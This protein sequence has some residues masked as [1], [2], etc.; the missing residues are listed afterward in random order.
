MN[1][2]EELKKLPDKPGAYIMK[3]VQGQIIYI[4]KAINLKNR[5]RSYFR[6]S[7]P[8]P[9]VASM[10][11][12]IDSFEYIVTDSELEA[13]ILECNLI[14]EHRPRYNILLKDDKSYPY[15]V[16]TVTESYPRVLMAHRQ[17][18][19]KNK[20]FGPYTSRG[21]VKETLELIHSIWGIRRCTKKFPRDLNKGRPCLNF[22]IGQCSAPCRGTVLEADY[23]GM[24]EKVMALLNGKHEDVIKQL[25]EK[26]AELSENMEF[27]KAAEARD[28]ITA[29]KTLSEKQ[30]IDADPNTDQDIIAFAKAEGEALFQVFFI[31]GGKMIGREHFMVAG[32]DKLDRQE[33][34]TGFIKQFYNEAAFVPKEIILEDEVYDKEIITKWLSMAKGQNVSL[35]VPKKGD[36]LKLI[37]LAHKN[38]V[39]TLMQF[40]EDIKREEAKTIG[41]LKEIEGVLGSPKIERIEAYDISNMQGFESV[42]SMV[43][44]ESGKPKRSGYRKFKIKGVLGP[45]DYASMQEVISRRFLRYKKEVEEGVGDAKFSKLPELILIDGG[46]GHVNAAKAALDYLGFSIM[47]CGMVKDDKHR[48][49]G[50]IYNE[51]EI[52]LDMRSEGFKLITR[53][54]DEVHRFAIEYHR[55]LREKIM[56]KSV[57]DEIEGIGEVRKKELIKH[58]G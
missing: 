11:K 48:T 39:L 45:N 5:V 13:L 17:K 23:N 54:Q 44:F 22:H 40:G 16:V 28:K 29:L 37:E 24:V 30:K 19:D 25:E 1:I 35:A 57:L 53:I 32:V 26:M 51:K 43:V 55:K 58:F 15:I 56:I 8:L 38:A 9:K 4:G 3:D 49:R 46:K 21:A 47:V 18:K 34:M 14:K 33:T 50:L 12:H 42:A 52:Y 36:K 2:Q 41:A 27:E 7:N 6:D 20:Y 10:V 31:R